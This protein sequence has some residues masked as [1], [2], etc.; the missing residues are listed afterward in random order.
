MPPP[1]HPI[2]P[3]LFRI[4]YSAFALLCIP[5]PLDTLAYRVKTS[6]G[7]YATHDDNAWIPKHYTI[8][9]VHS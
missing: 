5:L 7:M 4:P 1:S 6:F 2:L 8:T 3:S 9:R